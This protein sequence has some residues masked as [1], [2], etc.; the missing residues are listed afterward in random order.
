MKIVILAETY[1]SN[2]GY[3][4]NMLPKY[5]ALEG[6]EVHLIVSDLP[7]NWQL[8]DFKTTYSENTFESGTAGTVTT[9]DG[10]TLHVLPH[11]FYGP[12][13]LLVGLAATLRKLRPQVVQVL[14]AIGWNP[15][16]AAIMK[17]F[18]GYAMFTASHNAKSTFP[19]ARGEGGIIAKIACRL[20]RTLPGKLISMVTEKC[21]APT[22][23]CAEIAWKWFGVSKNKVKLMYLGTDTEYF[24]PSN[25]LD[26]L[27]SRFKIRMS[28]GVGPEELLFIYTGK[29]DEFKNPLILAEVVN[30]LRSKGYLVS[31]LFIGDGAQ[32]LLIEKFQF[33][34]LL[35]FLPYQKLGAYYRAADIGVWTGNESTSMIDAGGCGLPLVISSLCEYDYHIRGHGLKFIRNDLNSLEATLISLMDKNHRQAMSKLAAE[36]I[37]REFSW[38]AIARY[39]IADFTAAMRL[40]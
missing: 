20:T 5:L 30:K 35:P 6:C 4:G 1:S 16:T 18:V 27:K 15:L 13:P 22:Y 36:R 2:M 10:F 11:K 3:I 38:R 14:G 40:R 32:K 7:H 28:I 9:H 39:R 21:Y 37:Q 31:A 12:W 24:F 33:C 29:M 26:D 23:D 19:L 8:D 17:P 34:H 25:N